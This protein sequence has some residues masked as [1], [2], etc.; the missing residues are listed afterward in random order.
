MHSGCTFRPYAIATPI[1]A[2]TTGVDLPD[3]NASAVNVD[4]DPKSRYP[5]E[6]AQYQADYQ[7]GKKSLPHCAQRVQENL[8]NVVTNLF[9]VNH[10]LAAYYTLFCH[11]FDKVCVIDYMI[12]RKFVNSGDMP[13]HL[14][15]YVMRLFS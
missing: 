9:R 2:P 4:R 15:A 6:L 7:R 3:M 10:L 11:Y 5:S 1:A 8:L 13:Y 14:G 12:A